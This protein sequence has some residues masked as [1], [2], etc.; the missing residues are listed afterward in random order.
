MA[1]SYLYHTHPPTKERVHEFLQ[2]TFFS[3]N[4]FL[5]KLK[6]NISYLFISI[7]H[8]LNE[9]F[10]YL[11]ILKFTYTEEIR[12]LTMTQTTPGVGGFKLAEKLGSSLGL[13][14]RF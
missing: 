8:S 12:C 4:R 3:Q 11:V 1:A 7:L 9:I 6:L 14:G 2:S 13:C 5:T 10:C